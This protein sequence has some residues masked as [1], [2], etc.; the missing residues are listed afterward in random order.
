[1]RTEFLY[2]IRERYILKT[3]TSNQTSVDECR[4]M[5]T[6]HR[7]MQTNVD[8]CRQATRRVQTSHQASVD[9]S[10]EEWN[11]CRR[12]TRQVQTNVEECRR[13]KKIFFDSRK[14][15]T[16]A[17]FCCCNHAIVG[18]VGMRIFNFV[19][20]SVITAPP[21]IVPPNVRKLELN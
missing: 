9:E 14:S 2:F 18:H 21:S 10:L 1:M 5:Q 8:K 6:I 19:L 4:Q 13:I 17:F 7:R 16:A 11:E 20:L 12:V 3:Q 15:D